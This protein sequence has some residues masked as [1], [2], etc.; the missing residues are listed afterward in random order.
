MRSGNLTIMLLTCRNLVDEFHARYPNKPGPIVA[1]GARYQRERSP[2]FRHTPI[3]CLGSQDPQCWPKRVLLYIP[4]V[5]YSFLSTSPLVASYFSFRR[6]LCY[7]HPFCQPHH[8]HL[9]DISPR[10]F[11]PSDIRLHLITFIVQRSLS[12]PQL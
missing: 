6:P 7:S 9:L 2:R 12:L 1:L 4:S 8:P 5:L 3:I 10:G 11:C